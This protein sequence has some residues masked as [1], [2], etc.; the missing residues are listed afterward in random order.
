MAIRRKPPAAAWKPGQSGN[1]KG[2]TPGTGEVAKLR[3]ALADAL[4]AVLD[5]VKAKALDGDMSAARLLLE[6]VLPPLKAIEPSQPLTLPDGTLTEQ[7]RAVLA[8]VAA[9]ELGPAQGAQLVAAIGT[10][11]RV[12]EVDELAA[13]VAALEEKHHAQP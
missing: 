5:T 7:G 11:A 12:T 9:G 3:A 13:R 8:S 4:P 2:R 10:L 6:R 1:P